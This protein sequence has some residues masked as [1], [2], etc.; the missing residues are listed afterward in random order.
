M[1]QL[2][3]ISNPEYEQRR[4]ARDL[5]SWVNARFME[6]ENAGRLEE[7]YFERKGQNI[8]RLIEEAVPLSR[9]GLSLWTP[10]NEPYV[11]LAPKNLNFD[12]Y[13][14]VEGFSARS[15][16]VEV[17]TIESEQSTLRRQALSRE[18]TVPLT[19]KIRRTAEGAIEAELAMIDV[20]EQ[21]QTVV[22]LALSRL[23][24][25]AESA[26]Y[27][28]NTA[29][30]VYVNDFWPL[31]AE[32]RLALHRKTEQYLREHPTIYS[33]GYCFSPDFAIDW[34]EV[35]RRWFGRRRTV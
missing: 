24:A 13:V 29:F 20:A 30:L 22:D 26:R 27:D 14:E 19:G 33:V 7:Q 34:I 25:K 16:S 10:G 4:H 2:H 31:P 11:T 6:L 23:R 21:E 32:G 8:K 15:F 5:V 18:G 1:N 28:E 12:G 9:L 35:G 17:T 3:D